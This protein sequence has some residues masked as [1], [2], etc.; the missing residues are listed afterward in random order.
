MIRFA[1][2]HGV[3]RYTCV[4]SDPIDL[5]GNSPAL[6]LPKLPDRFPL[7]LWRAGFQ[8]VSTIL[9]SITSF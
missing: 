9:L 3:P 4:L 8:V 2:C 6:F 5:D 7:R 1:D